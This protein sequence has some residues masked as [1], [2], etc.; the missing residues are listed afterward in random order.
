MSLRKMKNVDAALELPPP[1]ENVEQN[2]KNLDEYGLAIHTNFITPEQVRAL[3]ER[4][5][6]QAEMEAEQGVALLSGESRGG[7]T[8]Y[9]NYDGEKPG[10]QGVPCLYNKGRIFID[11]LMDPR[12]AEYCKHTFRG[13]V[14]SLSSNTG[15]IVNKGSEPMVVHADQQYMPWTEVPLLLNV[16]ITL[17]EFTEDMGATRVVPKTHTGPYPPT[18]YDPERGVYNPEPIESAAASV[19]P[20]TA[21]FFEGRLWHQSGRSISDSTRV[22]ITTLW[23]Q[24][25]V[26][27]MDNVVENLH[28]DV[29]AS[30]NQSEREMLGFRSDTCNRIEPRC[31]GGR[32]NTN[33][34]SPFVPEL[35]AGGSN[36]ATPVKNMGEKTSGAE[37]ARAM[38]IDTDGHR[39]T[40]DGNP[41]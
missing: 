26:Q 11:L 2:K 7:K 30:L 1:C 5:L 40:L 27:P 28:D 41:N 9:G 22:S 19:P 4:L 13:Q 16:M 3:R 15:L 8:W 34:K 14:H 33:R 37:L 6:E 29:Y 12:F 25:W 20:G 10:W 35:R 31:P 17:S 24:Y 18:V 38:G 21:I 39:V 36:R 23:R 32:Q